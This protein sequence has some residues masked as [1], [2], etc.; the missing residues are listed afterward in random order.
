MPHLVRQLS[1]LLLLL[2]AIAKHMISLLLLLLSRTPVR[3]I[4]RRHPA[5]VELFSVWLSYRHAHVFEVRSCIN[6]SK[7]SLFHVI[8]VSSVME[9]VCFAVCPFFLGRHGRY[10]TYRP[11]LCSK[12]MH[13]AYMNSLPDVVWVVFM[14]MFK[15]PECMYTSPQGDVADARAYT[16]RA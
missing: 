14:V 11:H 5:A 15:L 3:R 7:R 16:C 10:T 6:R 13:M 12:R 2:L 8:Y 9:W 4:P 1:S